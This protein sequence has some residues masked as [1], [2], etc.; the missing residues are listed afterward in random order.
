MNGDFP[1][2]L[3]DPSFQFRRIINGVRLYASPTGDSVEL[4]AFNLP[5][6]LP[7]ARAGIASLRQ[8]YR[9]LTGQVRGAIVEV[10][11]VEIDRVQSVWTILKIPQQPTGM[12]YMGS[13]TVPFQSCSF[14]VKTVCQEVGMTGMRDTIVFAKMRQEGQ[15]TLTDAG[16][17]GWMADPYD[18]SL[19]TGLCRNLSEDPQHDSSFPDHPLSRA[20]RNLA[21]LAAG[22]QLD[23]SLH[24]L[25]GFG[26]WV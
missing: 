1:I 3:S 24:H 17:E 12:T 18:P 7:P 11:V 5:P 10:E 22:I 25:P 6:D 2:Q 20:R 8:R 26:R 23:P 13:I 21:A 4:H 19:T 14:V 15:V 9:D 16:A